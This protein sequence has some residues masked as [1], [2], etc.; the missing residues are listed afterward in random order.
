MIPA[1]YMA[2]RVYKKPDWLDAGDV[3]D[4]YSVSGCISEYF[5]DYICYWKHNGYWFF[6]TPEIISSIAGENSLELTGTALFYYESYEMEFDGESWRPYAPEPSFPTH[7]IPPS[8]KQLEG[9]DV[10]TFS[11]ERRLSAHRFRATG[12]RTNSPQ[13]P[14]ACSSHSRRRRRTSRAAYSTTVNRDR[15]ESLRC[16]LWIGRRHFTRVSAEQPAR[17]WGTRMSPNVPLN[18]LAN[19]RIFPSSSGLNCCVAH[20]V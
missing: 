10:V 8:R 2:K 12:W 13:M 20:L 16:I 3:M 11:P 18:V 7:I 6:D 5:A 15:I 19:P 17:T 4:V 1:G 9:F 14:T